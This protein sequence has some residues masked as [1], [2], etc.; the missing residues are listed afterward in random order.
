MFFRLYRYSLIRSSR[1]RMTVFW[2]LLFPIILGSLFHVAFGNY[3]EKEVLFHQVPVAYVE[4]DGA[5]GNFAL[6]LKTLE[7]ENELILVQKAT[8][9]E[10]E[11]LL[12]EEDV[13]GIFFNRGGA[14]N[15]AS[16]EGKEEVSASLGEANAGTA[17]F[18]GEVEGTNG[19]EASGISLVVAEQ[20]M[21]QSILNS[22]LEQYGH[23]KA[24]LAAIGRE[25]PEGI[26]KAAAVLEEECSYL[27]EGSLGDA[28]SNSILDYFYSLI[29]MNCLMG[30]TTGLLCAVEFKAD[31]SP[32]A[33]RRMV[34]GASRFC[35]LWPDL[36]AKVTIQFV[37]L[38][39]S[40][41]YLMGVLDV[42]LGNQWGFLLLA[43]FVGSL[44]GVFLGFFI[45]VCGKM[46]YHTKEG[47]CILVMMVSS[48]FSGLM[49]D[50]IQRLMER[51]MPVF[52]RI[53]PATLIAKAC[54]SLNIYDTYGRYLENIGLMLALAVAL[55]AGAFLV[56]RRERYAGI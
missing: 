3:T 32:L 15:T 17:S 2:N 42:P 27:K 52:A 11:K 55:A 39:F 18:A 49:V 5:D 23:A 6:L 31:L 21:N 50:G 47:L 10:A 28:A 43:I 29:A 51:Y 16:P 46:S 45:G 25:R 38:T 56:V 34:A 24:T 36:A 8:K 1:D 22:V 9:A 33:A 41:G 4:E 35:M 44:L 7:T 13:E 54:C 14:A 48:F 26:K 40:T 53:N 37:Y 20:G 19:Q 30:A 12:R